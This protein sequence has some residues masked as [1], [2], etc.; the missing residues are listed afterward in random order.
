VLARSRRVTLSR[1]TRN[2]PAA[3][4]SFGEIKT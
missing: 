3:I 1:S 4:D 2:I